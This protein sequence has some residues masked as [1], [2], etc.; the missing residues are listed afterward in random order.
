MCYLTISYA[1]MIVVN[2]RILSS[3]PGRVTHES[4]CSDRLVESSGF[5]VEPGNKVELCVFNY[6]IHFLG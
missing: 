1:D 6:K 3:D 2:C 4:L 5:G